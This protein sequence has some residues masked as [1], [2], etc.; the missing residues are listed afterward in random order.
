[1]GSRAFAVHVLGLL[2]QPDPGYAAKLLE[3]KAGLPRFGEAFLARALAQNVGAQHPSV[4]A[5]LDGLVNAAQPQGATATA[6]I[7]EPGGASMH[8]YMSDDVRTTAIVTDAIIDLRPSEPMLPSLVKGL[9]GER[10]NGRW[11]STQDNL[12]ALVALTHYVKSR[13]T[14]GVSVEAAIGAKTVLSGDFRGKTTHIR[15]ATFPIDATK[16]PSAPLRIKASG[17]DVY[18]SSVLRFRR[19][20][21]HQKPYE[22]GL[23]VRRDYLNPTTGEPIDAKKGVKVGSVVR[24]RITLSSSE[25]RNHLAVDDPVPAGLEPMNTRLVTT[26][27][28]PKK[29]ERHGHGEPRDL[30]QQWWR[31]AFREVRDDRVLVFIDNFSPAPASFEYLARAT[32]AGTFVVPGTSVEEMYQPEIAAR[33]QPGTFV[34]TP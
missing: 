1:M 22:N 8:W 16:P 34:V 11:S 29:A 30:D 33:L 24:V 14:G 9:F 20:V 4:V 6:L 19:D 28:A 25:R 23:T 21:S 17:G 31:P 32:T 2:S 27:A 13:P 15:R 5:L 7:R 26:G 10:R 3:K 12:Y 18:Y